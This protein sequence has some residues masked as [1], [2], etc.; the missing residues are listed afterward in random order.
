MAKK[1]I[2]EMHM[3]K[4]ALH[5]DLGVPEDKKISG[6]KLAKAK[7]SKKSKLRKRAILAATLAKFRKKK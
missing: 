3:K 1:W 5:E 7:K 6:K 2:Q 4:G